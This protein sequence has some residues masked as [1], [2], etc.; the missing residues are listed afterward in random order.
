MS[1]TGTGPR[2]R[3]RE[4]V[5]RLLYQADLTRDSVV[6]TW[7][8]IKDEERLPAEA[9]EYVDAL[10][11]ALEEGLPPL[12]QAIREATQHWKFER[13][14]ATD[15][16]V[17][18]LAVA[19]LLHMPGTPARVVLDEAVAIAR[20]YGREE[21]GRFVNGV[22]DRVARTLRPGELE[23]VPLAEPGPVDDGTA[24]DPARAG[25]R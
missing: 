20:K 1:R 13:L 15:R 16:G 21:S 19:E 6:E 22:L 5:F 14:A 10:V 24:D 17:L 11:T 18:R 25:E 8:Q 12:D 23:D 3:G 9:R 2:R 7:R 4:L